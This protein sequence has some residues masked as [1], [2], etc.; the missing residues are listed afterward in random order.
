MHEPVYNFELGSGEEKDGV[1]RCSERKIGGALN[2]RIGRGRALYSFLAST[3]TREPKRMFAATRRSL[4][5]RGFSTSA[6]AATKVA[7]L[8]AA[9]PSLPSPV[10]GDARSPSAFACVS[11]QRERQA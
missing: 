10:W 4:A 3:H 6:R 11:R 7:V 5:T 9:G 1:R 2:R 8:G